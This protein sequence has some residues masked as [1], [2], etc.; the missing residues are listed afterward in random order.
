MT[1]SR[2]RRHNPRPLRLKRSGGLPLCAIGLILTL[3]AC[4]PHEELKQSAAPPAVTVVK[5]ALED[6]RPSI[7]FTGRVEAQDKVD[8]RARVQGF[9]ERRLF[10]EGQNVKEGDLL[11]VIEKGAYEAAV[12]DAQASIAKAQASLTLANVEVERQQALV[13]K[14]YASQAKLDEATARQGQARAE[15]LSGQAALQKAELN[16][17][18]TNIKAPMAGRIGRAIISVGNWVTPESGVLAT[19]VKQDPIYATFPVTQRDL[20]Q[21]R[22]ETNNPSKAAQEAIVHL[23]LAD[24]KRYAQSGKIN[25]IDVTANPSTDSLRLRAMFPNPDGVLVDGQ[26]VT[27]VAEA[28][29][30]ETALTIPQQALQIDQAGG[31]VLVVDAAHK[32]EMRRIETG[33][34]LASRVVVTRGLKAGEEVITEGVQKVRAG[35]LVEAAEAKPMI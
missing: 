27:V 18:Y 10:T 9:L 6:V 32:V 20:L 3:S 30:A 23:K 19:I 7:S 5:A 24:G 34:T 12:K 22:E 26:L 4:K 16:L 15:L 14:E 8:L 31:F 21:I 1:P 2:A 17:G 35:Q 29:K 25:F 33:E 13:K 28:P 11:F